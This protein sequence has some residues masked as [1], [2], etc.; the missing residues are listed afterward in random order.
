[1]AS[2][3][4][5]CALL[6][7]ASSGSAMAANDGLTTTGPVQPQQVGVGA[8]PSDPPRCRHADAKVKDRPILTPEER[9]RRKALKAQRAAQGRARS[10]VTCVTTA[11]VLIRLTP[12]SQSCARLSR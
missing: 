10:K 8:R 7:I 1:M 12:R 6:V 4:V 5:F 2:R 3:I 9:A 11:L